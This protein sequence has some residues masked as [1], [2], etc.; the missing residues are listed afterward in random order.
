MHGSRL[1]SRIG[2]RLRAHGSQIGLDWLNFFVAD[3][4]TG[5][6]PFVAVYLA[7][8]HWSQG[9]IGLALAIG[10]IAGVVSQAPGGALVDAV[11]AKRALI[12]SALAMLAA[13]ALMFALWPDFW[14]VAA[15]EILHGASTGIVRPALAALALGLVG[16]RAFSRRLGRN[17]LYNS[18][19]TAATAGTMGLLGQFFSPAAPFF[20]AAAICVPAALALTLIRGHEIDYAQARSAADRDNP[21]RAHRLRDAARNRHLHVFFISLFL[22]QVANAA[23]LPLATARLGYEHAT[24]SELITSGAVVVPQV[25]TAILAVWVARRADDWGRKPLLMIGFGAVG[26]RAA[27]FALATSSWWLV[28]LQSLDGLSAAVIGV[29]MPLVIADL[30]RGTGRYNLAQ[31]TAGTVSAIGASLST[32]LSGYLVE[33]MGYA[34]GFGALSAVAV[35]GVVAIWR[36]LPETTP[37]D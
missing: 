1:R 25:I 20:V 21:R 18:L 37:K 24:R 11:S 17:Q 4:Q 23:L 22:F 26:L 16:H 10:S 6:G 34:V 19:G 3:V 2:S 33:A 32:G 12:G 9:E 5:F 14:S 35:V 30:V 36:F 8:A 28:P 31:G 13:S 7:L 15:A 29:L 27:L